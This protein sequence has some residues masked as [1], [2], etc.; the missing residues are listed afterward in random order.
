MT[1]ISPSLPLPVPRFQPCGSWSTTRLLFSPSPVHSRG[2]TPRS[3]AHPGSPPYATNAELTS[4]SVRLMPTLPQR[5]SWRRRVQF[6]ALPLGRGRGS[7]VAPRGQRR[8]QQGAPGSIMGRRSTREEEGEGE[9]EEQSYPCLLLELLL[10]LLISRVAAMDLHPRR[11]G[12]GRVGI[13][14]T[15]HLRH[16]CFSPSLVRSTLLPFPPPSFAISIAE[17]GGWLHQS[18]FHLTQHGNW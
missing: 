10:S 6:E 7:R 8:Q 2:T 9:E 18:P 5:W 16:L 4:S 12:H 3:H 17:K 13:S 15:W 11:T 1:T 14:R